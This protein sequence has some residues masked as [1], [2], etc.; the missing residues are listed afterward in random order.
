MVDN[1]VPVCSQ[2]AQRTGVP[3][4]TMMY[5]VQDLVFRTSSISSTA[6]IPAKSASQKQ[7][8]I[9]VSLFGLMIVPLLIVPF[10]YRAI[11]LMATPHAVY[12]DC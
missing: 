1:A 3:S 9:S 12:A 8:N 7:S 4:R 2:V 11:R 6:N 5:P 10:R